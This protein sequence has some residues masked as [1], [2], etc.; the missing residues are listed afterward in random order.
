MI[1]LPKKGASRKLATKL[2]QIIEEAKI[3]HEILKAL[4]KTKKSK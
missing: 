1:K 2:R 4:K 3:P